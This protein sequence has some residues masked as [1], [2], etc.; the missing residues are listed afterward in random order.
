MREPELAGDLPRRERLQLHHLEPG[1]DRLEP[2]PAARPALR[3]EREHDAQLRRRHPD[4]KQLRERVAHR[5]PHAPAAKLRPRAVHSTG[6]EVLFERD[7]RDLR[8]LTPPLAGL[9]TGV[10][11][12]GDEQ[13][14]VPALRLQ[15][16]RP[17]EHVRPVA[18][19]RGGPRRRRRG[20]EELVHRN[21]RIRAARREDGEIEDALRARRQQILVSRRRGRPDPRAQVVVPVDRLRTESAGLRRILGPGARDD[22]PG[23]AEA[24]EE[25]RRAVV[26]PQRLHVGEPAGRCRSGPGGGAERGRS[27]HDRHEIPHPAARCSRRTGVTRVSRVWHVSDT[28]DCGYASG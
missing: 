5:R 2:F 10:G 14:R 18:S 20:T 3:L 13:H 17:L 16:P 9:A 24:I 11:L 27:K 25:L 22:D 6:V 28:R 1:A 8:Q 12:A 23:T 7:V 15:Q 19:C 21:Q 26:D 4:R